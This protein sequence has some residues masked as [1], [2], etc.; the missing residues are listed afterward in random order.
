MYKRQLTFYGLAEFDLGRMAS[1]EDNRF[2][3]KSTRG[4][5]DLTV[6]SLPFQNK[7]IEDYKR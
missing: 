7:I 3:I 6:G 1:I 5:V 4:V 2:F